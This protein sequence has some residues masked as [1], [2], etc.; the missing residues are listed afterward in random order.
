MT[1]RANVATQTETAN[2]LAPA[3][4]AMMDAVRF[5]AATAA[6][7]AGADSAS[8]VARARADAT[9]I[10]AGARADG[11][12]AAQHA[13][14]ATIITAKRECREAILG[15]QRRAYEALRNGVHAEL[16]R[17]IDSPQGAALLARLAALAR[18]RLGPNATVER[19]DDGRI[20]VRATDAGR[21]LDVPVDRF[22][23]RE[24][25]GFSD[26]I[27]ALWR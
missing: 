9:A 19:L 2:A 23:D 22:I 10:I 5:D 4:A 17:S 6:T 27:A 18:E 24:I 13:T 20:G 1:A 25:A 8:R 7:V 11:A 14:T 15:A 21:S 3:I 16:A 12:A 26:R